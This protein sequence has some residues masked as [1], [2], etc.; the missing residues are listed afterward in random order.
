MGSQP[1]VEGMVLPDSYLFHNLSATGM[2]KASVS[3]IDGGSFAGFRLA[4]KGKHYSEAE[5]L[6]DR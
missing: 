2:V 3:M 4:M 1:Q 5:N 6:A